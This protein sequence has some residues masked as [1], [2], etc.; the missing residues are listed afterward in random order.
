[1]A[2]ARE[3][4]ARTHGAPTTAEGLSALDETHLARLDAKLQL[5]RDRTAGVASGYMTGLYLYGDGGV[6]KSHTVIQTLRLRKADFKL[7]NSRMTGRGL[8]NALERY[9]DS[10]HVLEDM[11][12]IMR[13][14]G[15]QGVLRSALWG[16]RRD[17]D[18]GPM[19]RPVTWSTYRMEHSFIFTGGII[20]IAN[21]PVDD[22]PELNAIK[23]RIAV[24]HL[25]ASD[26]EM[27]ALMR[28]VSAA[29]FDHEGERLDPAECLE[30]CEY[31]IDQ[32]VSLH[33]PLDMR[34]LVNSF[35]DYIQWRECDSGVHWRDLVATRLRERPAFFREAVAVGSRAT[36]KADELEFAREIQGLGRQARLD[37]WAARTGKSEKAL[38]RRLAEL[39]AVASSLPHSR[40]K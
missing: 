4:N 9:P 23:T 35:R 16:Q 2:K 30:V 14:R 39:A 24:V 37:A 7:F 27:R 11:E 26:A 13:D 3:Q 18:T 15:A 10:V 36:R 17:G 34:L 5:V 8:F 1:M 6:G 32:S 33:R 25:Q 40:E 31:V 12:Q 29:G 38:Y 21:R 28:S 20:M 22:V 19:E